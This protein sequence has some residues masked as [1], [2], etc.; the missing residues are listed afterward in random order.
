M[1]SKRDEDD[2]PPTSKGIIQVPLPKFEISEFYQVTTN[3]EYKSLLPLM[4][5]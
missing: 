5:R 4:E 3:S 1:N 2:V